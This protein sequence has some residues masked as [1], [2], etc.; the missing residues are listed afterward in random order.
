MSELFTG[1]TAF[2]WETPY[3]GHKVVKW[4]LFLDVEGDPSP[5]LTNRSK[6]SRRK[7]WVLTR[8]TK[9][10]E[11]FQKWV[12]NP[13]HDYPGLFREFALLT[14]G[15]HAACRE[16]ADNYGLL[17]I[18]VM[19]DSPGEAFR[20]AE[21]LSAWADH[22]Q[23]MARAVWVWD[24]WAARDTDRLRERLSPVTHLD[25]LEW[26][27]DETLPDGGHM[28]QLIPPAS[29][30]P[31][32]TD[33]ILAP[34]ALLLVRWVNEALA[35]HTQP[36]LLYDFSTGRAVLRLRPSN[37]LGAMWLQFAQAIA[38]GDSFRGCASCGKWFKVNTAED[39]RKARK[40]FC[41][42]VCKLHDHRRRQAEALRLH[43]EGTKPGE[44]ATHISTPLK[45]VKTWLMQAHNPRGK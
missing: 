18:G 32:S 23:A 9:Q 11:G 24:R 36:A 28:G 33:D 14:S 16:F 5:T 12:Y 35:P 13:L 38:Q 25:P 20:T 26:G 43:A 17:G 21:L 42:Q 37:L 2:R 22:V 8:N 4:K 41:S 34:A 1:V 19:V 31:F 3:P 7:E 45:T 15:N 44:I 27:Y 40:K 6:T 10:G 39:A 29:G 30:K